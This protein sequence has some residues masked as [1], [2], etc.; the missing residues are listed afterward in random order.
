[1]QLLFCVFVLV[2]NELRQCLVFGPHLQLQQ[3]KKNTHPKLYI[4][5]IY[6]EKLLFLWP[7]LQAVTKTIQTNNSIQVLTDLYT[8]KERQKERESIW[9]TLN[10]NL[11]CVK[12]IRKQLH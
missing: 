6:N 9:I 3:K 7:T 2:V 11:Q 8:E 12:Y 5:D 10:N 4:P 1:M